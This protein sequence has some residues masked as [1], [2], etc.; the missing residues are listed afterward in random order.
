[1]AGPATVSGIAVVLV[2]A[3]LVGALPEAELETALAHPANGN[4]RVTGTALG[5]VGS[6]PRATHR[7][8]ECPEA[9]LQE[10]SAAV[11]GVLP[12]AEPGAS[13]GSFR[14]H[15]RPKSGPNISIR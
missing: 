7:A 1:M 8:R 4:G 13:T 5:P 11:I 10:R 9:D 2:S 6:H 3:G 15:R 12:P 14:I